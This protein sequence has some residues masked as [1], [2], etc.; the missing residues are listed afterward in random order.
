MYV[1]CKFDKKKSSTSSNL[2]FKFGIEC[3]VDLCSNYNVLFNKGEAEGSTDV[4]FVRRGSEARSKLAISSSYLMA[5]RQRLPLPPDN[6]N[7]NDTEFD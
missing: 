4:I 6:D 5:R 2:D 3:W 1:S 7:G